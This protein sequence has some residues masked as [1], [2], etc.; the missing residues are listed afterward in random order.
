[1][2]DQG[3]LASRKTK[4]PAKIRAARGSEEEAFL[5]SYDSRNYNRPSVTV[6]IVIFTILDAD[7]KV[8]LIR[9]GNHPYKGAWAFPGGFLQ[10]GDTAEAQG[11]DL[12][13][14]AVRKLAEETG[15]PSGSVFLEQLYTFG[16]AGRDPRM[17]VIT[18]AY[19]ALVR[20]DLAPFVK[21]GAETEDAGWVSW[22]EVSSLELAFDHDRILAMAVKRIRG[23][24]DYSDIAF[25]LVP[26]TFSIPELRA[27][28]EVIKGTT[29]DPGNFR[30]RFHRMVTDG[31]I[32]EAIGKRITKSK[33]AQVYRFRRR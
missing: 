26:E 24:V 20:P 6:D 30:R 14:A 17:R 19:Y 21:A 31:I 1:M 22:S 12:N 11:E 4:K 32:E 9:R 2:V 25:E 18:V 5:E 8:L 28:Y 23:K 33:P 16:D 29:Y 15:L 3:T 27:V 7:L 13:A 10:V